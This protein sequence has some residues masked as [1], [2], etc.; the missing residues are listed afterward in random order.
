MLGQ[1]ILGVAVIAL[2]HGKNMHHI[3]YHRILI[4]LLS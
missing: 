3:P 2:F 4:A 1:F